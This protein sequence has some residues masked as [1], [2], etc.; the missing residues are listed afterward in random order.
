MNMR[1]SAI[2]LFCITFLT[3]AVLNSFLLPSN[4]VQTNTAG[5][6]SNQ[7]SG[8]DLSSFVGKLTRFF[9]GNHESG[10]HHSHFPQE[11]EH[12]HHFHSNYSFPELSESRSEVGSAI[13]RILFANPSKYLDQGYASTF[14]D[15][16]FRPP[17]PLV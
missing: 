9:R 13:S 14:L 12:P 1:Q 10:D 5:D 6:Y 3:T 11:Q 4:S 8:I 7:K 17:I 2:V 16:L 15:S